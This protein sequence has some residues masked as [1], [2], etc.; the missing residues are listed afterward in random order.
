MPQSGEAIDVTTLTKGQVRKLNAL[1]KSVGDALGEKVFGKWLAKQAQASAA[2]ED[3]RTVGVTSPVP[4]VRAEN[5][6]AAAVPIETAID[7]EFCFMAKSSS[8]HHVYWNSAKHGA[9]VKRQ[10]RR[11]PVYGRVFNLSVY[12]SL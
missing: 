1:R 3:N 2:R 11:S 12:M 9:H 8:H 5:T 7:V 6:S 10:R 4:A